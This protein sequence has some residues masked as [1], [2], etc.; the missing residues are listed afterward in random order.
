M[1]PTDFAVK[2]NW[3]SLEHS[4]V[5]FEAAFKSSLLATDLNGDTYRDTSPSRR[6]REMGCIL[7]DGVIRE[8]RQHSS[9]ELLA[10]RTQAVLLCPAPTP[11]CTFDEHLSLQV[12]GG[13]EVS[14]VATSRGS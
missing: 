14:S 11:S 6:G 9:P 3:P 13:L 2:Y 5:D 8:P 4:C 7:E 1:A 12:A 10:R